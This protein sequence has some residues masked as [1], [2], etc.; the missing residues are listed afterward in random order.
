MQGDVLQR[1]EKLQD[2]IRIAHPYYADA[3][4]YHFFM[5]LTQS[6]DLVRRGGKQPKSRYITLAAVRPLKVALERELAKY[7]AGLPNFPIRICD[8][9]G[10]TRVKQLLER[11]LNNTEPGFFFIRKGS[12]DIFE[13]DYCVFLTLTIA[14][15]S[16][17]Y[18]ECL[19]AKVAQLSDVFQAKVGWLTGNIYSRVGTP[20]FGDFEQDPK[21][22]RTEFFREVLEESTVWLTSEQKR[23]LSAKIRQQIPTNTVEAQNMIDSLDDETKI[24]A[25][26]LSDRI[27]Q[28]IIIDNAAKEKIEHIISSDKLLR[29]ILTRH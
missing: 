10:E 6:C 8:K 18:D 23:Q 29:K 27:N 13:R 28:E 4:D 19:G 17:H 14:I 2:V 5:V 22:Y 26:R 7:S 1:T 9:Q 15:R 3:D 16:S 25:K 20:D 12:K 24:L 11:F 21:L